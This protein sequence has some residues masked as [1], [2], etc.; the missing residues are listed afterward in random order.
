PP[1]PATVNGRAAHLLDVGPKGLRLELR[2]MI[3]PGAPIEVSFGAMRLRGTVLWCQVDTL[4]FAS[5]FDYYLAGVAFDVRS[6]ET[7]DFA[8][9]LV[10]RGEAMRIVEMRAFDRY[11]ITAPLTGSFG[12]IAPVSILDLSLQGARIAMLQRVN[13][14]YTERLR[15]QVDE[16]TGPI[17]VHATVAWCSASPVMREFS[18]GLNIQGS[19]ERLRAVIDTLCLRNEARIDI[20]SLKRKFDALRAASRATEGPQR[21]AV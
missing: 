3:G 15:F 7:E 5:D 11:R 8:E 1:I 20:D 21:L 4:N 13:V 17:T 18:A 9:G 16:L 14:G 12:E 6:D 19:E 10:T 2:E